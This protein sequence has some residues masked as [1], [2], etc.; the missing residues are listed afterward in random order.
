MPIPEPIVVLGCPRSGTSLVAGLL[1]A[2]GVWVGDCRAADEHNPRGYFENKAIAKLRRG[3]DCDRDPPLVRGDVHRILGGEGYA[4]SVREV[5]RAAERVMTVLDEAILDAVPLLVGRAAQGLIDG[6]VT[7]H[8][9]LYAQ[10]PI[11]DVAQTLV[12]FGFDEP[13]FETARTR[14]GRLD[15]LLLEDDGIAVAVTRCLPEMVGRSGVDLFTGRS[16]HTATLEDVRGK[17]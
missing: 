14:R 6:G 12:E 2:H 5:L 15:R 8:I 13:D 10:T 3:P 7:V 17:L 1:H 9:R 16:I 4:E 11:G